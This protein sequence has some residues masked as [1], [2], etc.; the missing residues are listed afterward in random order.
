MNRTKF[1][2]VVIVLLLVINAGML[3]YLLIGQNKGHQRSIMRRGEGPSEYIIE[4]LGF[5]GEQKQQFIELR[6]EHRSQMSS[7]KDQMS[8][9]RDDYFDGLKTDAIDTAESQ[10]LKT[11]IGRLQAEMHSITFDHFA[12]VRQICTPEQKKIFDGFIDEIL[13]AMA[14]PPRGHH[15]PRH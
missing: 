7:L 12:K 5:E 11:E 10:K 15:P 1:L 9:V 13:R 8:D 14:P 2:T 4:T 3:A 6:D